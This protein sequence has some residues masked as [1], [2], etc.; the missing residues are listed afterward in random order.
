MVTSNTTPAAIRTKDSLPPSDDKKLE[1][2]R[3]WLYNELWDRGKP[4]DFHVFL[5]HLTLPPVD[6]PFEIDAP[7]LF[8]SLA[9][10]A[11]F[12]NVNKMTQTRM[13]GTAVLQPSGAFENSSFFTL[14]KEKAVNSYFQRLVNLMYK[15]AARHNAS[16]GQAEGN[17]KTIPERMYRLAD[18]QMKEIPGGGKHKMDLVFF[19][20]DQ[21]EDIDNVHI[22]VEGKLN[23]VSDPIDEDTLGQIADYQYSVWKAQRTRAFV[24]VLL[25]HGTQLDLVAFTRD[26]WYRVELGPV[27]YDKQVVRKQGIEKVRLTMARLYYLITRPSESFGHICNVSLGQECLRFAPSPDEN[28]VLATVE[29]HVMPAIGSSV[30]DDLLG[31]KGYIERFVHPRGR[32]AHVFRTW[33]KGMAA[34]LKLSWTP[35]DRMPEGAVYEILEQADVKGVP[36]LHAHGLLK[37]D[38]FGYRLEYL[39][40]ED[41]GS[42]IAEYLALRYQGKLDS[43]ELYDSIKCIVRHTLSCLVQARVKGNIL[44]RDI[45]PGN[46][47]ASSS[48]EVK[49]IDWGYAKLLED[50]SL[51]GDDD[52][53]IASRRKRREGAALKWDYNDTVVTQNEMAHDPLTG[54]QLYMSI[55]VLA[56]AKVRGL[57][58]DIE[59]LFYVILDVLARLQTKMDKAACGLEA[60][61]N[62]SLAMVRAGCLS[63]EESFLCFFG[64]SEGSAQLQ[65]LLCNLREFLFVNSDK[66]IASR[67]I[68]KPETPRGTAVRLLE[69]YADVDTMEL[70]SDKGKDMLTPK[71]S[72]RQIPSI[73]PPRQISSDSSSTSPPRKRREPAELTEEY[74]GDDPFALDAKRSKL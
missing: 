29:S 72:A 13:E 3:K 16:S 20:P 51:D 58:D 17:E 2:R 23:K 74:E 4:M 36:K 52:D 22:A 5:G 53:T 28:S 69:P 66:F 39:I 35:V 26:N 49:I 40:L 12:L 32:L 61:D 68:I 37:G 27:C 73:R 63:D 43:V 44:H 15:E 64:I 11:P 70:L 34:I 8:Q 57:P 14:D 25:L 6:D 10:S 42:T 18:Y 56:G 21:L 41:C 48:G 60:N 30:S 55:P 33:Y 31:I 47:M 1:G 71:K 67:L 62:K 45:S 59:S 46:I 50:N 19:Y 38:F 9:E 24:P 54:T 7:Q 65:K